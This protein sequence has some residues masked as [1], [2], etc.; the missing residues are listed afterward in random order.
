MVTKLSLKSA[1]YSLVKNDDEIFIQTIILKAKD[2]EKN[3]F[4]Y[5]TE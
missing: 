1:Y 4:I 5:D 3:E 2:N